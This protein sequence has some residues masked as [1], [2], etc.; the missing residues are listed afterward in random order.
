MTFA[1]PKSMVKARVPWVLPEGH[2]ALQA[3]SWMVF[4][5][6]LST[7]WGTTIRIVLGK[8]QDDTSIRIEQ[9]LAVRRTYLIALCCYTNAIAWLQL[10]FGTCYLYIGMTMMFIMYTFVPMDDLPPAMQT[11]RL[12][13]QG[14]LDP[15]NALA[16]LRQHHLAAHGFM[17]V[18]MALVPF[19]P[20]LL[21]LRTEDL[22]DIQVTRA[23]TLRILFILPLMWFV[24]YITYALLCISRAAAL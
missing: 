6:L 14:L 18:I 19:F 9:G 7:A 24:G 12:I 22:K 1:P 21:Y 8:F 3:W 23:K 20:I 17:L 5:V 10:M 4:L 2:W 11:A 13:V 15:T 16:W